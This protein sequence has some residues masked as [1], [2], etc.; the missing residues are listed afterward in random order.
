MRP[1]GA[2]VSAM[3][4]PPDFHGLCCRFRVGPVIWSKS[5]QYQAAPIIHRET[6]R[7]FLFWPYQVYEWLILMPMV[8]ILTF[9][10]GSLTAIFSVLVSPRF[11]SRVFA[12]TWARL[13]AFMIPIIVRVEGKGNANRELSYVVV[14]NHQ[15]LFDIPV[16]YGWLDLDL[17]W[18]IKQELRNTTKKVIASALPAELR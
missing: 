2:D 11:G 8:G 10:F 6:M 18:V 17:K 1:L 14:C 12:V 15:S 13:L 5:R 16:V 7:T 3:R 4:L 9:T